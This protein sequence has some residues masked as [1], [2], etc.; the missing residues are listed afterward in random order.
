VH[1]TWTSAERPTGCARRDHET[2]PLFSL[3]QLGSDEGNGRRRLPLPSSSIV[4]RLA[5]PP[6][7]LVAPKTQGLVHV[8]TSAPVHGFAALEIPDGTCTWR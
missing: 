1:T 6:G 4:V 7:C 2:A 8:S 5:M 3:L